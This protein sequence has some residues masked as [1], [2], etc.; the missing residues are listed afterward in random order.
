MRVIAEIPH[1]QI[2]ISIFSW[3]AKYI[4]KLE[5]AQFEQIYKIAETDVDGLDQLKEM[6]NEDFIRSCIARFQTMR[7]DFFETY[8]K[9]KP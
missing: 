8:K 2:R 9:V 3:N 1:P 5:A 4:V 6:I 7:S